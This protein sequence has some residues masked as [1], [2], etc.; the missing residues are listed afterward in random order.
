MSSAAATQPQPQGLPALQRWTWA[1]TVALAGII[2]L[3]AAMGIW[4]PWGAFPSWIVGM[5]SLLAFIVVAGHGINGQF[6]GALI[7]ERNKISLSRFQMLAWTVVTLAG[8]ATL[9][10]AR[11]YTNAGTALDVQVPEAL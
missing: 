5:I 9:V 8:Y 6:R 11:V 2:V 4:Q 1:H 7:D 3:L 10:M